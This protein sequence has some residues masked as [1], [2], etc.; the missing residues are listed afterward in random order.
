[1]NDRGARLILRPAAYLCSITRCWVEGSVLERGYRPFLAHRTGGMQDPANELLRA[2][3]AELRVGMVLYALAHEKDLH[4]RPLRRRVGLPEKP[5]SGLEVTSED[6]Y[7][8][9]AR[10]LR[11]DLLRPQKRLS[12]AASA[13]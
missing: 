11:R 5:S 4:Y 6:A 12:L 8:R 3:F 9:P 1:M 10:D 13:R 2:C 7:S